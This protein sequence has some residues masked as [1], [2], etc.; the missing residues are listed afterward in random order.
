MQPATVKTNCQHEKDKPIV[1]D[2]SLIAVTELR[3][4]RA[5][6]LSTGNSHRSYAHDACVPIDKELDQKKN[7]ITRVSNRVARAVDRSVDKL[8]ADAF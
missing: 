3:Y 5:L 7:L 1:R 4:R 6:E 8:I 2:K